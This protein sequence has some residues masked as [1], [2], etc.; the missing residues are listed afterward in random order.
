MAVGVG[1]EGMAGGLP[2]WMRMMATQ[3]MMDWAPRCRGARRGGGGR[4]LDIGVLVK[5]EVVSSS[6]S[7]WFVALSDGVEVVVLGDDG[8]T[9]SVARAGEEDNSAL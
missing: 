8:T 7:G 6:A 9:R 2:I 3:S 1:E 5:E 4:L